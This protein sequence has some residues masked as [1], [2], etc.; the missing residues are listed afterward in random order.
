[1]RR[2]TPSKREFIQEPRRQALVAMSDLKFT[3]GQP[4]V[5]TGSG[6]PFAHVS[7]R[8]GGSSREYSWDMVDKLAALG[9]AFP[10]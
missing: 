6:M 1:M 9:V 8:D 7:R 3:D 10:V 2:I 5:V 4:A